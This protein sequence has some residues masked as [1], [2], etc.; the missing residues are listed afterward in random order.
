MEVHLVCMLIV[1]CPKAS[2][3]SV[4]RLQLVETEAQSQ[5]RVDSVQIRVSLKFSTVEEKCA[6]ILF[7]VILNKCKKGKLS[8]ISPAPAGKMKK[9]KLS[10]SSRSVSYAPVMQDSGKQA[11]R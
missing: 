7:L 9:V 4:E 10:C 8:K 11:L 2:F 3:L 6:Y 5:Q 1:V